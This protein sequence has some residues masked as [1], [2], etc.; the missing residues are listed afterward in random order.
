MTCG[1]WRAIRLETYDTRIADLSFTT[2]VCKSLKSA[3]IMVEAEVEG[4]ADQVMFTIA[5]DGEIIIQEAIA[6]DENHVARA[7]FT[8]RSPKLWYPHTYG[9]QPLYTLTATLLT[10]WT[11]LDE[12]EKR[13]GFRRVEVIQSK[14][15]DV[16]GTSFYFEINNI[17]AFCGGS[18]WIPADVLIPRTT[19][20]KYY[21]WVKL[22]VES[23]Q[24]MLRV[25]GGGIY[26]ETAFYDACDEMGVMVWQDFMFA[27]GNYPGD[28]AFLD[29]VKREAISNI[30]RLRHHS[31]IVLFA[32]N[33]E[34]YQYRESENLE[35][36]PEDQNPE[37][38]L[39]TTF[40]AR[41][42][43]EK[44]LLEAMSSLA[45]STYYHFGSPYGGKT[46]ADPTVGDIHQW[47]VWH[48]TQEPY[49]KFQSLS[50]R[51]VTEFGMQALPSP[52]TID[53]FLRREDN[54]ERYALS[55]TIDLH[56]KA[57][58]HARRVA[59]YMNENLR[60][61][62]E[63]LESYIFYTQVLQAECI[64]AAYKSFKRNWKGPGREECAG[65]LV[66]QLNDCWPGTSWAIADY[67]LR[68]KLAYYAV[69]RELQPLTLGLQRTVKTIPADKYTRAYVKTVHSMEMW[70]VNFSLETQHVFVTTCSYD[71]I[72]NEMTKIVALK[73][74]QLLANRSTELAMFEIPS[75]GEDSE[76]ANQTVVA[77]YLHDSSGKQ[78]A[79]AVNW[80]EP[81]KWVHFP[82]PGNIDLT[83]IDDDSEVE[84]SR[85]RAISI[86]SDVCIKCLQLEYSGE[87]SVTFE[88]NGI[89]LV[90]GEKVT[91]GAKGL[92]MGDQKHLDVKYLGMQDHGGNTVVLDW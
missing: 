9:A 65:A 78:L 14:L 63:P 75:L 38:W 49:Q 57:D 84:D 15:K 24:T 40:P 62:F 13:F 68:P 10:E 3:E 83:V 31:S 54:T 19:S 26:E 56:N 44:I 41:Y 60:Y 39:C 59:M 1:P 21:D 69:K 52:K 7:T 4:E 35:Y 5:H 30:K 2:H 20:Q 90:P 61:S 34:D 50:G 16:D 55:S 64:T 71:L 77:A 74:T 28:T 89:D 33:N 70:A 92:K 58:G 91:V 6:V 46:S 45:P 67:Y 25:W 17:P 72:S 82:K 36:D 42:I 53:S 32:G 47:N 23:N 76:R 12:C 18:N 37:S 81:L 80:P 73:S 88:D 43:Y 11:P 66:W 86:S 85:R 79:R 27:C 22:A 29:L 51:F 48:G 8:T 87:N